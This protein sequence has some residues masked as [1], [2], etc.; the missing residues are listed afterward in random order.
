MKSKEKKKII[1][2]L[3]VV[4]I[5]T[6]LLFIKNRI[7]SREEPLNEF[8]Q[9]KEDGTKV[10]ISNK[11]KEEKEIDGLKIGNIQLTEKAGQLTLLANITNTTNKDLDAFLVDII[12]YNKQGKQ[13]GTIVGIVSPVKSGKTI[14]LKAGTTEMYAN[15]YDFEVIK[16]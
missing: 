1:I 2:L 10:N 4:L 8:I 9:V 6:L 11:L 15:A 5:I 12:L 13:I 7:N 3:I 14:E 16:K